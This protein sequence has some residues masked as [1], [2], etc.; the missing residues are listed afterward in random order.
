MLLFTASR[1]GIIAFAGT[2][3]L[4]AAY[5][6]FQ[7]KGWRD[8]LYFLGAFA[9]LAVVAWIGKDFFLTLYTR[10]ASLLLDDTGR[11]P[12]WLEAIDKFKQHP[13][14]GNGLFAR[15]DEFGVYRMFHNTVLHTLATLGLVGLAGLAMQV[16]VQFK[17]VLRRRTPEAIFLAIALLGAHM[18]G[19]VDNIYYMPQFMIVIVII[20]AVC[21]N[22]YKPLPPA[23][24]KG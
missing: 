3:V 20:V 18:H 16:F 8:G 24:V 14:F 13:L 19:M 12:I 7:K 17:W 9:I 22:A 11:I 6:M 1:G 10:L 23:T 5:L 4:C 15:L 2:F 21:E